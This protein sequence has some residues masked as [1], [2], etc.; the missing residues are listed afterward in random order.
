MEVYSLSSPWGRAIVFS[1]MRDAIANLQAPYQRHGRVFSDG[2]SEPSNVSRRTGGRDLQRKSSA[3]REAPSCRT[4]ADNR[5]REQ[6]NSFAAPSRHG[7]SRY[8][9]LESVNHRANPPMAVVGAGISTPSLSELPAEVGR[10]QQRVHDLCNHSDQERQERLSLEAWVEC[11]RLYRSEFAFYLL[12]ND[13]ARQVF[14]DE[15]ADHRRQ[16]AA[17]QSQVE[18]LARDYKNLVEILERGGCIR[19]R[20]RPRGDGTGGDDRHKT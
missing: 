10:L 9:P 6:D 11:I 14:R 19:S 13:R 1:E 5:A 3:G 2:L 17:L 7:G 8:A 12:E 20:K 15:V 4:M 18:K 16:N